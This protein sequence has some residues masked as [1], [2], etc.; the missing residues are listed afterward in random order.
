M[1][2]TVSDVLTINQP[3]VRSAHEDLSS[4]A[5]PLSDLAHQNAQI[6]IKIISSK[7]KTFQTL[8]SF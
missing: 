8:K 2:L 1:R 5:Q 7:F 3:C 6:L 4:H